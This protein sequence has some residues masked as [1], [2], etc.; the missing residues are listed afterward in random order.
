MNRNDSHR[1]INKLYELIKEIFT[2]KNILEKFTS[3][4]KES[5]VSEDDHYV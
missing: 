2:T 3:E 5:L 4:F 1:L